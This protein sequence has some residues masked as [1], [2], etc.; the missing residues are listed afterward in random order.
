MMPNISSETELE[1]LLSA[2]TEGVIDTM[3]RHRGDIL[4]LGA[5]GKMG[6]SL[7]RMAKR[8]SDTAGVKR[9]IIAVSRFSSAGGEDDFHAHGIETIRCD[10]LQQEQLAA[11]PDAP[12]IIYMAGMKFGAT[13]NESLTWAMNSYL[14]GMVCQRFPN[15]RI[16]AFSTGNVYHL[17]PVTRG[18]SIETDLPA[19]VGEYAQSCLGRERIFEHF[20][21]T[22]GNPV[23]II[24]LT[25]AIDMRYGVLLDMGQRVQAGLPVNLA[26]GNV[27]VIWQADANAMSLQSLD[28]ADS[29]PFI[30]NV[31]GAETLSVRRISEQY[32][33]LFGKSP[34]F[35]GAEAPEA[36][37]VSGQLSHRLFGYPR[38]GAQ[39]LIHWTADWITQ[40]GAVLGKPTHF[41]TRDG[42]F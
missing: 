25:Y 39:Q 42:K 7:A 8:A 19:P 6:P 2:P 22:Q 29:P 28:F 37:L 21:R 35:E 12:L 4:V 15:S 13:G 24:R 27:N 31:A 23:S 18:G 40:G 11:L 41:E 3:S 17:T 30:L 10:L 38:V 14:P 32:G 34:V 5:A 36:L 1:D 9:R 33:A 20:S 16:V 26:M